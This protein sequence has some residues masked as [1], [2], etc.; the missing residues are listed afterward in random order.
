[1]KDERAVLIIAY[2][3]PPDAAVG[4]LRPQKFVKYLPELGWK[5]YVL[6][7]KERYIER[8]DVG[9]LDDVVGTVVVRTDFWR[10]PLQ[11]FFDLRDRFLDHR[12]ANTVL[13]SVFVH[14]ISPARMTF[15]ARLKRFV[16]ELNSFPDGMMYWTIPA[17]WAGWRIIRRE[18]IST[19][20]ATAPPHTVCLVGLLLSWLTGARLVID[21]RD[22]WRLFRRYLRDSDRSSLYDTFEALCERL[23]IR[24]AKTVISATERSTAAVRSSYPGLDPEKFVTISNGYDA[25]DFDSDPDSQRKNDKYII[26]YLQACFLTNLSG[27]TCFALNSRSICC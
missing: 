16:V 15:P 26:S 17:V 20:Y 2:H 13:D 21:F 23:V 4:A 9:R 18:R 8:L 24:R 6:T 11:F 3:F 19:L 10:T 5:P 25:V 14:P 1:M 27:D 7:I 22:P 12:P